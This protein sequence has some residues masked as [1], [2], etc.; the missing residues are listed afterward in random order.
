MS[1]VISPTGAEGPP[2]MTAT[3][4]V[5]NLG[6]PDGN[7][8]TVTVNPDGSF[9][10]HTPTSDVTTFGPYYLSQNGLDSS[11]GGTLTHTLIDPQRSAGQ[12]VHVPGQQRQA[13]S[14]RTRRAR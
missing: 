2:A 1:D 9:T 8:N 10:V 5:S 13:A 3:R 14:A 6:Y 4:D 7:G 12:P 11:Q